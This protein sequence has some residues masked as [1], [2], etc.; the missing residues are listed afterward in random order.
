MTSLI[1]NECFGEIVAEHNI[2]LKKL[3]AMT[4][5]DIKPYA[6]LVLM[7]RI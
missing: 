6:D 3:Q 1:L 4:E 7:S 5:D 2:S